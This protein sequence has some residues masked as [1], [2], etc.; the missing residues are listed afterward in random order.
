MS[1]YNANKYSPRYSLFVEWMPEDMVYLCML[2]R[3]SLFFYQPGMFF[4]IF[5]AEFLIHFISYILLSSF[6]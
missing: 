4:S 3:H 2:L 6:I 1:D 5:P